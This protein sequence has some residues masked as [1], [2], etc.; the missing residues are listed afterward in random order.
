LS[1]AN[2]AITPKGPNKKP[3]MNPSPPAFLFAPMIAPMMPQTIQIPM[4]YSMPTACRTNDQ[5][6][7]KKPQ[8]ELDC[9]G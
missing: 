8:P 5:N 6:A 1:I 3:R 7:T 9:G 4:K 2:A